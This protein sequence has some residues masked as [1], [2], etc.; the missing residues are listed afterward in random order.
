MLCGLQKHLHT[1]LKESWY[2]K[3]QRWE[4]ALD[5]YENRWV[6]R[7]PPPTPPT[8]PPLPL[9]PGCSVSCQVYCGIAVR[10]PSSM[11]MSILR[12]AVRTPPC[13]HVTHKYTT[14]SREDHT[15]HANK[16][17]MG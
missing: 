11:H 15:L 7:Y 9:P 2:E 4:E 12:V 10:T 14:G 17:T 3:L 8:H 13:M 6:K 16:Y 5:A 1:E